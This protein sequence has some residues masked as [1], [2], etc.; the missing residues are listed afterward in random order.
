MPTTKKPKKTTSKKP[1]S[2]KPAPRKAAPK[3]ALPKTLTLNLSRWRSGDGRNACGKGTSG[4]LMNHDGHCCCLGLFGL[5]AGLK[6]KDIHDESY[7]SDVSKAACW[8]NRNEGWASLK[9]RTAPWYW[10]LFTKSHKKAVDYHENAKLSYDLATI[11]DD[12]DHLT[13]LERAAKIAKRLA[14]RG[15]KLKIVGKPVVTN[16]HLA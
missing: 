9:A 6:P 7:P 14:R 16:P 12:T 5:Q 3:V 15:I 8:R 13:P 1:A 2:K 11:N 4:L 10:Q